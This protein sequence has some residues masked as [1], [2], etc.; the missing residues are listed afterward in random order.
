MHRTHG[1]GD[2]LDGVG[3][4]GH[5]GDCSGHVGGKRG[6]LFV[7]RYKVRL[8]VKLSRSAFNARGGTRLDHDAPLTRGENGDAAL[9]RLTRVELRFCHP[10]M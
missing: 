4:G 10:I 9:R 3:R 1:K 7:A 2:A 8:A 6:K 5:G